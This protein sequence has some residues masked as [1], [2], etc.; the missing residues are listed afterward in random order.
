MK[1][2]FAK[3][4]AIDDRGRVTLPA[5]LRGSTESF[6]VA[7]QKD[8]TI[9]LVPQKSVSTEDA[10]LLESLKRSVNQMKKGK[11]EPLPDE[12]VEK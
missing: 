12:W 5:E 9:C 2:S 10:E 11:A 3:K 1:K 4:V 8:G 6:L 7:K